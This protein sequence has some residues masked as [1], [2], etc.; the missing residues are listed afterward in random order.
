LTPSSA[1]LILLLSGAIG[2]GIGDTFY[3]GA[4]HTIGSRKTLLMKALSPPSA[5][6]GAVIWLQ[7][8]LSWQAWGGILLTIAGVTWVIGERTKTNEPQDFN[9]RGLIL[10]LLA[11]LTDALGAVLSRIALTQTPIDPLWSA[12]IRLVGGTIVVIAILLCQRQTVFRGERS[13]MGQTLLT[14]AAIAFFSTFLG[15]WL[16]QIALKATAAGIAQTL[17]A[18][19]PLFALGIAAIQGKRVTGRSLLGVAIAMGGIAVLLGFR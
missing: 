4:L 5:A 7:E 13:A 14:V 12:L 19:S 18:T 15:I 8:W 9:G 1:I 10:G 17:G 16:Q 11:A 3:F 2:I 6:I